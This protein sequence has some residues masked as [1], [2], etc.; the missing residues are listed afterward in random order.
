MSDIFDKLKSQ[1][2]HD[3]AIDSRLAAEALGQLGEQRA[4]EPLSL[5]CAVK[6]GPHGS[7]SQG[8]LD[9]WEI[10]EQSKLLI[11]F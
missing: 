5:R 1:L 10:R 7:V 6:A 9:N 4:V 3:N 11:V 2:E 8:R